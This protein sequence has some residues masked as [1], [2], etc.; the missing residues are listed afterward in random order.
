MFRKAALLEESIP[1]SRRI[2]LIFCDLLNM[3]HGKKDL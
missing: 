3:P 2:R 1:S